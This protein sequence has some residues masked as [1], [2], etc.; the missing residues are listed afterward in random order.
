VN[1]GLITFSVMLA[2]TMQALDTTIANV[3]LPQMQGAMAATRD[4]VSWVLTSYVVAAAIMTAPTSFLTERFGTKRIFMISVSG[5][6]VASMAA[7][8]AGSLGQLVAF[9]LMQGFFGAALVPI[10][11]AVLLDIYPK[12]QHGKAIAL[13]GMGVMVGPVIGPTL[14]GWLTEM[15]SWRW[16]FY[17]NLP[18]GLLALGGIMLSFP[19]NRPTKGLALDWAGFLTLSLSIGALQMMLDRG[20][21]L[22]WFASPEIITEA[23]LFVVF[24]YLFVVHIMTRT[25]APFINPAMFRDRNLVTGLI[26]MFMVGIILLAT[27]ALLPPFLQTLKGWPVLTTGIALAP[28]GLGIMFGMM[29]AGRLIQIIDARLIILSGI[30]LLAFSLWQMTFF[31]LDTGMSAIVLT[32]I[33]QGL[34]LGAVFVPMGVITFATLEPHFR[35]EATP[36][37]SLVRNI[38]SSLGVSITFALLARNIQ[39]SHADLAEH[40]TPFNRALSQVG[41]DLRDPNVLALLDGEIN[42]QATTI[43]FLNDF[44]FMMWVSLCAIPLILILQNPKQTPKGSKQDENPSRHRTGR[45]TA[46]D[47]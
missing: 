40:I 4:Q 10:S 6:V 5:F 17:I 8:A 24:F 29:L 35:I 11:Q 33:G 15:L 27:M 20:Q 2:T 47:H 37:F 21:S 7:G 9:R 26:V 41:L 30:L 14:G 3:A 36:L 44:R 43:A 31:S 18:I 34:G 28:R 12:E 1:R 38:G 16:V 45:R 22:D 32:G 13:W 42:R 25:K 46:T 23:I 39:I 19:A